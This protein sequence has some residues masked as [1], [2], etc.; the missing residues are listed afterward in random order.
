M[1]WPHYGHGRIVDILSTELHLRTALGY[2]D[3]FLL[4]F[5][6]QA[7]MN[8]VSNIS[9]ECFIKCNV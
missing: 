1:V 8:L 7:V 5:S 2:L 3:I 6:S 9:G 4:N